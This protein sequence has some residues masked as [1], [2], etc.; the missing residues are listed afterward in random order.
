M[1]LGDETVSLEEGETQRVTLRAPTTAELLQRL[2]EG[3]SPRP[4]RATLRL[5]MLDSR[6]EVPLAQLPVWLHWTQPDVD[7]RASDE[8]RFPGVRSTTDARGIVTFCDLPDGV[9]LELEVIRQN[10]QTMPVAQFR[11]QPGEITARIVKARP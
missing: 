10:D 5:T 4:G 3:T 2:C 7:A 1:P 8:R 11:L 9:Q 6:S